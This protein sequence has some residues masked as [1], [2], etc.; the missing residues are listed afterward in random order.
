MSL[1]S[2]VPAVVRS[3][4]HSSCPLTPSLAAKNNV[5]LTFVRLA[6]EVAVELTMTVPPFVPSLFHSSLPFVPLLAAKNSVPLTF[7]RFV[8]L[9]VLGVFEYPQYP[10]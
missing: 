9:E 1:T 10:L 6:T 5:P 3:L 7:V 8:G 2:V 4:F